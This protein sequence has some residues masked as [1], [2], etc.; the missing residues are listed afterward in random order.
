MP[1][2]V[3]ISGAY[4]K[5]FVPVNVQAVALIKVKGE[6]EAIKRAAER[7]M[8]DTEAETVRKVQTQVGETLVGH[9][10]SIL[11]TMTVEEINADRQALAER[12]SREAEVDLDKMGIGVDALTIQ[13]ILDEHKHVE[14][15][16]IGY[17]DA[18]GQKS[19][20]EVK[21][22]A[23]I[24]S[25]KARREG[26]VFKAQQE[27]EIAQAERD[28]DLKVAQYAAEVADAQAKSQ[29]AGPK[30]SAMARQEV[31]TEEVRIE[32]RRKEAETLVQEKE[33]ERKRKELEATIVQPAEAEKEA[34]VRKADGERLSRIKR[35]EAERVER[36]Q[37]GSG[38]G[39]KIREI[40]EAEASVIQKKAEAAAAGERATL[41][42]Q[43]EG[44]EKLVQALNIYNETAVRLSIV[45]ELIERLPQMVEAASKPLGEID[46]VVM[47][48]AGS[49]N[50][51]GPMSRFMG[52][53]PIQIART[54]EI[55]KEATGVDVVSMLQRSGDQ[56]E[57]RGE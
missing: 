35:A 6:D 20:A 48:D 56:Q 17:M 23:I 4:T 3:K 13:H 53:V 42:A 30:A 25:S 22:D 1:I 26:D 40:G 46:R 45:R 32:Q 54:L 11:A 41:L 57:K 24:Q 38:E 49:G 51:G 50:G 8:A 39:Q 28:R 15:T 43:A 16:E 12:T 19:I 10:R 5:L 21:R 37:E 47:I 33:I 44:Q 29:Q 36:E 9:L 7:Y 18:L 27:A 31:V 34:A 52:N 2:D 14:E 55:L